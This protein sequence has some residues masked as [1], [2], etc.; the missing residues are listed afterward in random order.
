MIKMVNLFDCASFKSC[1][2]LRSTCC[3]ISTES[4][5]HIP[6]SLISEFEEFLAKKYGKRSDSL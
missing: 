5:Q 2:Q 1:F 4:K 3:Q 6:D